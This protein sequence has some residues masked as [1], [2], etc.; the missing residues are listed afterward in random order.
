MS[1]KSGS[2]AASRSQ[3]WGLALP[4]V[5]PF[6]ALVLSIAVLELAGLSG[7]FTPSPDI[8]TR[9]YPLKAAFVAVALWFCLPL[10]PELVFRDLLR[11]KDTVFSILL[12]LLVF[13]LWI[14]M[15][16]PWARIGSPAPFMPE[17]AP[18]GIWRTA[19]LAVRFTGAA[20]LVPLAEE[21]FWRSFLIR[22]LEARH[23]LA[24][25]LGRVHWPS[26]AITAVLFALEHHQAAAGLMAGI[27]YNLALYRTK[28]ITQC[29][30]AHAVTNAAL[31]LWVLATGAWG[32]W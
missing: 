24:V 32:F 31:G 26:F 27:L 8:G 10:C 19:L 23:F 4:R 30:L 20:L 6:I 29:V 17:A 16:F 2:L 5:L 25:P 3:E 12:G 15:D 22:A 9:V 14:H 21:L 28:S 18:E 7:L 13:F 1:E 11:W